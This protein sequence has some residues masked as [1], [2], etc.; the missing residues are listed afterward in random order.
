LL[1]YK[2]YRFSDFVCSSSSEA[3]VSSS[4]V[5]PASPLVASNSGYDSVVSHQEMP[6]KMEGIE[7]GIER[8]R[9][10]LVLRILELF[11]CFRYSIIKMH[12]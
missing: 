9:R 3:S 1:G 8:V 4:A 11:V 6:G 12:G 5:N 2:S 10:R 7:E